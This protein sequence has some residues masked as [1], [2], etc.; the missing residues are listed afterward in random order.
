MVNNIIDF[1]SFFWRT[2]LNFAGETSNMI[3]VIL[4]FTLDGIEKSLTIHKS[5]KYNYHM[6]LVFARMAA[7]SSTKIIIKRQWDNQ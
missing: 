7:I 2:Y 4:S 1:F 5:E 6:S 3:V